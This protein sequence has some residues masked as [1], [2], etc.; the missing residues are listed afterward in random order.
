MTKPFRGCHTVTV[1]PFT[2]DGSKIDFAA[3][4]RHLDWQYANGAPGV[5]VL[6][7][8]GEFLTV[9]DA[10]RD[11]YVAAAVAHCKGRMTV[12]VGASNAHTPTAVRHAREAEK[13][14]AHG[15][16]IAPP[17]YYTPTEDEIFAYYAAISEA[18]SIP[19]ML[20][21][22][23][24]TTN[25]DMKPKLVARMTKTLP[26]V[27]YIKEASMD[28]GRV[29]DI[30]EAT[31]GVM[32]VF[33][34]E[35]VVE[36][37]KLG[38]V[39]YVDPNANFVPRASLAMFPLLEQGR[40]AEATKIGHLIEDMWTI[41]KEGHPLYGHQC[42]SKAL[43]AAAGYPVGDV[44]PPITTF[45]SLGAEGTERV[46]KLQAVMAKLDTLMDE[47]EARRPVGKAA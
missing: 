32:N 43:S 20:Y 23:P 34:G 35:R 33:A 45:K 47:I 8:T 31:Q 21:N 3:M 12:M 37:F 39:G 4:R 24:F 1:T 30:V 14:G 40:I 36:S 2:E 9:S 17:Y 5:I 41:I 25:V 16:M 22:N 46:K 38:A 7:T 18:V 13:A 42:Y 19:I 28:V 29:F 44:R 11:E 10:E 26:N 6:G 27:R 15:L